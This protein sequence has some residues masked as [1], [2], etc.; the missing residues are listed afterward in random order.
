MLNAITVDV[1]EYFHV[2]LFERHAPPASWPSFPRRAA[3]SVRTLLD[4]F[5]AK[6]VKG[7]F[8]TLGW[9]AER[10][11]ELMREIV[12]RGHEV[13]SH[14]YEHKQVWDLTPRAF[15]MDL[16]RAQ[17]ALEDATGSAVVGFRAPSWSIVP[18]TS[19]ALEVLAEEGYLYDSSV[20][21]I[22]HDRYGWPGR[23][24]HA[25]VVRMKAGSIVEIPPATARVFGVDLPVA[26][27]GYLRHFP[28]A[29]I[30]FGLS[31]LAREG[32]PAVVYLH[33]WEIDPGQPRL[34]VPWL[35]RVRHYR[36]LDKV[37]GRV[38]ELLDRF[39]FGTIREVLAAHPPREHLVD[40]TPG[41]GAE[42]ADAPLVQPTHNPV[43]A[44]AP[45]LQVEP[46]SAGLENHP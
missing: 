46:V 43:S 19:W 38:S 7:T 34:D 41:F 44:P 32:I 30:R 22:R 36:N 27:G 21:P 14:G 20:F 33:P 18:K 40:L 16:R 24:R 39:R 9:I 29:L 28:Q 13:A 11:P 15:R 6:Q 35:S 10:E 17:V 8:F 26:G 4:L 12:S 31:S 42:P 2:S 37:H 1:E 45:Q 3:D 5:D 25:H 23:P